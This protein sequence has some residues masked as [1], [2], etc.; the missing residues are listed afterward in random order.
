MSKKRKKEKENHKIL[1]SFC[2]SKFFTADKT[3]L[4]HVH[5]FFTGSVAYLE[6]FHTYSFQNK[7]KQ[8]YRKKCLTTRCECSQRK[9]ENHTDK[10][11]NLHQIYTVPVLPVRRNRGRKTIKL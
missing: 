11:T 6:Y 3:Q 8:K 4:L 7:Q 2:V 10:N 5:S 9:Y 1:N